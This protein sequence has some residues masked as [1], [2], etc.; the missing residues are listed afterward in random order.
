MVYE[1]TAPLVLWAQKFFR[2]DRV[3]GNSSTYDKFTKIVRYT[4]EN[5]ICNIESF[6]F[7]FQLYPCIDGVVVWRIF[8]FFFWGIF[9]CTVKIIEECFRLKLG[10][11][12]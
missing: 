8:V 3:V 2:H 10:V 6:F 11:N 7:F 1:D 5:V 4:E 9:V 12:S